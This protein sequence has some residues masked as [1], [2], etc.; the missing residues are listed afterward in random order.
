MKKYLLMNGPNLNML[1]IREPEIYGTTTLAT[2]Q[3]M[4]V[5]HGAERGVQVDCFQS[6]HEGALIDKLHEAHTAYDGVVYNP[7]AHT[8]YSYGIRD[9]IGS[10]DTPVVEVHISDVDAREP[11]RA[12]SVVAPACVAQIKG[13]GIDGYCEALDGLLEGWSTRL[14]EGFDTRTSGQVIV[15][16]TF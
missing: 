16:G 15:G 4:V 11:F 5:A 6:N 14:G 7:G 2:I 8:H 1:G 9:A 12:I 13:H 10:I 3:D